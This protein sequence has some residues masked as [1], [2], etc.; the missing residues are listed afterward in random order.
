MENE[1]FKLKWIELNNSI[2]SRQ[3]YSSTLSTFYKLLYKDLMGMTSALIKNEAEK[4]RYNP[5]DYI[6]Q[7]FLKLIERMAKS[8]LDCDSLKDLRNY[9]Y[10]T[11]FNSFRRRRT[12]QSMQIKLPNQDE[13]E[14][15]LTT[16]DCIDEV[17]SPFDLNV[18]EE[19][20]LSENQ[21]CF[22]LFEYTIIKGLIFRDLIELPKYSGSKEVTLRQRK[23]RC[24]DKFKACLIENNLF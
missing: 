11:I 18:V 8:N 16:D 7:S 20:C 21:D 1:V 19:L 17:Y 5:E 4:E 22:I 14:N 3:D 13:I 24:L 2:R 23:K 6:Q 15:L 12:K 9:L 10:T